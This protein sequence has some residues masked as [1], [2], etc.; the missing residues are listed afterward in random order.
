MHNILITGANRGIGLELTKQYLSR[1]DYVWGSYRELENSQELVA[2]SKESENLSI[3]PLDV[4]RPDSVA[5]AFSALKS[6][7][8]KIELLFNNAGIIDW[9]DFQNVTPQAFN[10]VYRVNVTGAFSVMKHAQGIL[11]VGEGKRSRIINLSSRLGSIELR[12][13]TQLGGA[14]A[15]QC[16][17]AALN[18]LSKQ[19]AIDLS[20]KSLSV[21][22]M[23]PGWVKTDMGGPEAKYEVEES[24]S[25]IL[26]TLDK[27]DKHTTGIFIGEDGQE[28]PW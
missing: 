25:L 13:N 19:S 1:G 20:K 18:M 27:L 2:L 3:F 26:R 8:I 28:I 11:D 23:S 9:N 22:S 10:D 5:D 7:G 12:G 17:K 14:L 21:I 16:S 24:V 15:Y 4:T 6:Q